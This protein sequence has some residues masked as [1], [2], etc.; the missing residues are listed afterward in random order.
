[1]SIITDTARE[2]LRAARVKALENNV[3]YRSYSTNDGQAINDG[4]R[5]I[6]AAII[7]HGNMQAIARIESSR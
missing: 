6:A 3:S 7:E 5:A 2:D 1:M 4:L